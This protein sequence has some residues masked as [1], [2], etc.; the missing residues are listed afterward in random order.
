MPT[1]NIFT[2]LFSTPNPRRGLAL[3]MLGLV[4]AGCGAPQ[5]R[6]STDRLTTA[7]G[8]ATART[9]TNPQTP[10]QPVSRAQTATDAFSGAPAQSDIFAPNAFDPYDL[11]MPNVPPRP[12][13]AVT[14]TLLLPMNSADENV[15]ALATTLL[16]AA[17]LALFDV[18]RP[19]ILLRVQDTAGTPTGAQIAAR[20]A[21]A[22]GTDLI[23]GPLFATSVQAVTPVLAGTN[24]PALAF[25]NDRSVAS[26]NIWLLGF[27]PEDNM[28][29]AIAQTIGQGLTRFGALLPEGA[30]GERLG[31]TLN[32][33]IT[34]YGGELVQV[35]IYPPD[36]PGMF[37]PVKRL[38]QY[39]TRRAAHGAEMA[40][41]EEE[42][43]LL[44]P[45]GTAPEKLFDAIR[46]IAPELVSNYEALKRVE[47]LGEIPYD[48]VFMPEG[49]LA[50]R[51]L[52]PLLPYFDVDPRRVK[53]VGTGLW[54]DPELGQEPPLHGGW[55]AAPEAGLWRKFSDHY[56][57]KFQTQPA[58]LASI[59]YDAVALAA[60]LSAVHRN[61]PFRPQT[62][63]D[64][65]GF[66]GIDGILR[67]TPDGL[68]ERGLAVHE[69]RRKKTVLISP[70]P[71]SFVERDR[72]MQAALAL[73]AT[74]QTQRA[75]R[76]EESDGAALG[77]ATPI[78]LPIPRQ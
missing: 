67:L 78:N 69:I 44:A 62:L 63:T 50:L 13:G 11:P 40:R 35:E 23:I 15:R 10:P 73:A 64:P 19:E 61:A 71:T 7:S 41:L 77:G 49:G 59:A 26:K 66:A 57:D 8:A 6:A 48:A 34:R 74:L 46:D 1:A 2:A 3:V 31:R 18:A 17:Q 32:E 60:R 55:Y 28:E 42:A 56:V 14:I 45:P 16:Q 53:F 21:L 39:E 75:T 29:R 70:A 20:T 72:R 47:T 58:R 68:A 22:A 38:A 37:E 30:Y 12:A 54:D 5:E 43:T 76:P 33:R 9:P 51:N 25:S 27:I 24:V 4:L 36:A 65:N 52:A